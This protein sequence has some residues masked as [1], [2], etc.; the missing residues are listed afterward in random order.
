MRRPKPEPVSRF[1]GITAKAVHVGLY[2]LLLLLPLSGWFVVTSTPVRVPTVIFG[3]FELP[4]PLVPDIGRFR[5]AHA[6]HVVLAVALA[7]L[8]GLHVAA[9]LVHAWVWRDRTLARM[10]FW[11]APGSG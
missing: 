3:L 7:A 9:G 6:A 5:F 4:Y 2:V 1:V 10:S 11:R 8:V